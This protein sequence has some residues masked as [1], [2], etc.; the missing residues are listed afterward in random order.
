MIEK[1][2]SGNSAGK[3]AEL[4]ALLSA[5]DRGML[6]A[7]RDNLD[8]DTGFA[9]I[10]GDLTEDHADQPADGTRSGRARRPRSQPRPRARPGTRLRG[11]RRRSQDPGRAGPKTRNQPRYHHKT[12]TTLALAVITALNI[13]LLCSLSYN[14]G[15]VGAQSGLAQPALSASP[16]S[17]PGSSGNSRR[18][19]RTS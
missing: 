8:L 3:D 10:L 5:A 9:Q 2:G 15:A 18:R 16:A 17:R 19:G 12:L 4:D 11:F 14:Y 7:I 6:D 13:V 1:D